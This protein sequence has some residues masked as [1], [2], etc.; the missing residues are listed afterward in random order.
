MYERPNGFLQAP[1]NQVGELSGHN[2][3]AAQQPCRSPTSLPMGVP[4]TSQ[5]LGAARAQQAL[6][7]PED[8]ALSTCPSSN[9]TRHCVVCVYMRVHVCV[10]VHACACVCVHACACACVCVCVHAWQ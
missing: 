1:L 2:C 3:S 4:L 9:T 10:C 5:R 6:H 8:A 7:M